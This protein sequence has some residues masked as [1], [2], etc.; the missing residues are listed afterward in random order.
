MPLIS[1]QGRLE[2]PWTDRPTHLVSCVFFGTPEH[3][4][5][6]SLSVLRYLL[7]NLENFNS[8]LQKDSWKLHWWIFFNF[9]RIFRPRCQKWKA[10]WTASFL[11]IIAILSSHV[12]IIK[13]F[14]C[15]NSLWTWKWHGLGSCRGRRR[16]QAIIRTKMKNVRRSKE[17]P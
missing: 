2:P 4:I 14:F 7:Y 13:R 10:I 9:L 15:N 17:E 5:R 11:R 3:F 12:I 8:I 1:D 6:L 16:W